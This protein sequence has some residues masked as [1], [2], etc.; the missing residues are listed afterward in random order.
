MLLDFFCI[1]STGGLILWFKQFVGCKYETLI[2]YFIKTILLDQKRT[3]DSLAVDGTVLRWKISDEN[4][5]IFLVAYQ[6]AYSLLYVDKLVSLVMNQFISTEL[7]NVT[8]SNGLYYDSYDYTSKFMDILSNW[9]SS[10]NKILEGGEDSKNVKDLFKKPK[11]EPKKKVNNSIKENENESSVPKVQSDN[12]EQRES[13]NVN[14]ISNFNSNIPKNLQMKKMSSQENNKSVSTT[15]SSTSNKKAV[16]EK[17]QRK[18]IGEFSEQDAK[19][20]NM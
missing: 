6:E 5:L 11:S 12:K 7:S 9:E 15:I 10:C 14:K 16:K 13:V 4:D 3:I 2:N 17:T 19:R 1:F 20:L 8:K 18:G